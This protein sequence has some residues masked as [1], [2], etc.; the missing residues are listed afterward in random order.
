MLNTV[1]KRETQK[2][3]DKEETVRQIEEDAFDDI[4]MD[5]EEVKR[6]SKNIMKMSNS[7]EAKKIVGFAKQ[8]RMRLKFVKLAEVVIDQYDR[9]PNTNK[10]KGKLKTIFSIILQSAS[11][12]LGNLDEETNMVL[13]VSLL[14]KFTHDDVY[15][16]EEMLECLSDKV[17]KM[18]MR[19]KIAKR[20]IKLVTFFCSTIC[21]ETKQT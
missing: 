8:D 5:S 7:T 19:R 15:L 6:F 9:L 11:D 4:E 10:E 16:C 21:L 17:K 13:V 12:I 1:R 18:T 14:K 20:M 3:T 2:T